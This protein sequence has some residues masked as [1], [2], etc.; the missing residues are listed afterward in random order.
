MT[1]KL[2]VCGRPKAEDGLLSDIAT[3]GTA[4]C[5]VESGGGLLTGEGIDPIYTE[6]SIRIVP[7]PWTGVISVKPTGE[8]PVWLPPTLSG[9]Q[10]LAA[11][12]AGWDSYGAPPIDPECLIK[13]V[14]VLVEA[15]EPDTPAPSVVP[16]SRGGVQFE[17]HTG[18]VDFEIEVEPTCLVSAYYRTAG[19]AV[20]KEI[21]P[22]TEIRIL[23]SLLAELSAT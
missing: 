15:M 9:L 1:D 19:G 18:G 23:K 3:T 20:E 13:A 7:N 12:P 10:E 5:G 17:W 14:Q 4:S 22:T 21:P 11:L 6:P 8:M 2:A 16:T